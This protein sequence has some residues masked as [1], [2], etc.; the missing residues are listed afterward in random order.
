MRRSVRSRSHASLA[1]AVALAV[2]LAGTWGVPSSAAAHQTRAD[3][4]AH[5][6]RAGP[7]TTHD[8]R[9]PPRST[10]QTRADTVT[11]SS[12]LVL[13]P[14]STPA[15][16]FHDA[17]E[18]G[19]G[20]ADLLAAE[21]PDFSGHWPEAGR[22]VAWA[23]D[24][25]PAWTLRSARGGALTLPVPAS[26]LGQ[27][28][29]AGFVQTDRFVESEL[30]LWSGPPARIYLDGEQVGER[31]AGVEEPTTADL[32][33][34]PGKHLLVVRTAAGATEDA[35]EWSVRVA[36]VPSDPEAQLRITTDPTRAVR[37]SDLLDT[38][39][40]S[41]VRVSSDGALAALTVQR[42]AVPSEDRESWLEI[43]R[44]SDG[45]EVRSFRGIGSVT[46]FQWGPEPGRFAYVSRDGEEGTLWA[47]RLDGGVRPVLRDVEGLGSFRW[48]PDGSG[49]VYSVEV[50]GEEIH[51][52]AKRLRGLPD[53][54]AGW[55]DRSHLY[56]VDL[57]G[58][59][60]Q[61]L[62]AG[63]ESTTLHDVSP[64]G[65]RIL[66]SRSHFITERPF[67]ET[68]LWELDLRTL[69]A[70]R[71]A[72]TWG[73]GSP[74]Y[75]PEGERIALTAGPSSF[76]G[77][78]SVLPD[79]VIPNDYDSQIFILHRE[80]ARVE[81]L[82][83]DFDPSV[84]SHS[85][86]R[87]D[88][89]IYL[90]AQDS[91]Y[92]RLFR[93]DPESGTYERIE[94]GVQV[95]GEF[96]LARNAPVVVYTGSGPGV[97]PRVLST[98]LTGSGE[99]GEPRLMT[100]PGEDRWAQVQSPRVEPWSFEAAGGTITGRIYYP[101]GFDESETYPLI[102]NYYGGT[103]PISRS[104]GGRY[105]AELWAALGY[106]VYIPQPSGAVGFGQAFSARHVNDWGE[107]VAAEI[108]TGTER[109][110]AEKSFLDRRR[111]GCIGASY[112]G[113]MTM[114]LLTKTDLFAGCV[115]HAG[116]SSISSYWGEGWWGYAYSAIA[117]AESYPWNRPELYVERSALFSA[118]RITTPL[119][120]L[121]GTED[122][123]VPPGE[124]EQLY[125]AL[126][127]L[128]REVE[129]VRI[130]GENHQ[131][132]TYPERTLWARTILAWFERTLKDRDGWWRHLWPES[133]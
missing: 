109:L 73:G 55:R 104:F 62:T 119:L 69:E 84:A 26:G 19:Y 110:L 53:R 21:P 107:R 103:F 108:I 120:L 99:L 118:D 17:A 126:E 3:G 59:V 42:P 124:S 113:F 14:T 37:L 112:G 101:P 100:I 131:I 74:V 90:T 48:L 15:P 127:L 29:L 125:T 77:A 88:G 98:S 23:A 116:I 123:N 35:G 18:E 96:D 75:G 97:P 40:V 95:V 67:S 102:V 45:S 30:V 38:E 22:T 82:S 117:T 11:V 92:S 12:W 60:T 85:W 89:M 24:G 25:D 122:T 41:D 79:S 132:F 61:R 93:L 91:S 80:D 32:D 83:R 7:A 121:H 129:Y 52:E 8:M 105:P 4:P 50:E 46:G 47:G 13:G 64:D 28:Y 130:L 31:A 128:D 43:R 6:T 58:G 106:V 87:A 34:T 1:M 56:R 27:A 70:E 111:I 54:W 2:A 72:T 76:E 65:E 115:A 20:P 63:E 114:Q 81:P 33:L 51:D 44:V 68:E 49:F 133:D 9:A 66:F 39:E 5:Q 94:T 16:I 86:S 78:G 71:L 36:L 10:Y 57:H